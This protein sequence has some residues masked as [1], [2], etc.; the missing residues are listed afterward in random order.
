MFSPK[1]TN[2]VNEHK[3]YTNT[4]TLIPSFFS[5]NMFE[6]EG[7]I[8]EEFISCDTNSD[9]AFTPHKHTQYNFN[10]TWGPRGIR[11]FPSLF[12]RVHIMVTHFGEFKII[13]PSGEP[14]E[15][16]IEGDILALK[17]DHTDD[18][19]HTVRYDEVYCVF[20]MLLDDKLWCIL[21]LTHFER[22]SSSNCCHF[23]VVAFREGR[24]VFN[25]PINLAAHSNFVFREYFID[26]RNYILYVRNSIRREFIEIN[27]RT[28]EYK[29]SK[30]YGPTL[31]HTFSMSMDRHGQV[32]ILGL[33]TRRSGEICTYE[34][35]NTLHVY[36]LHNQQLM[37]HKFMNPSSSITRGI[38]H[39][40]RR[41]YYL[42]HGHEL[43]VFST[44]LFNWNVQLY[45][46]S[47]DFN[48]RIILCFECINF[49]EIDTLLPT[50]LRAMIYYFLPIYLTNTPSS[51]I[52]LGDTNRE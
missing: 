33:C 8:S 41:Q 39:P 5:L 43:S 1:K 3:I 24:K 37:E 28:L 10:A 2:S 46:Q 48:R 22:A 51:R 21:R 44:R 52:T 25:I 30:F 23:F 13:E 15:Y 16:K 11:P 40:V 31:S 38:H 47:D 20:A 9:A 29:P 7:T 17:C 42:L 18:P 32:W 26:C 36:D 14:R 12:N 19:C 27:M 49:H 34:E 4:S 6:H 35:L 45:K 50:E